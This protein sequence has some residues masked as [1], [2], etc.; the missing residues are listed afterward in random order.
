[1]KLLLV[2]LLSATILAPSGI[3]AA[4]SRYDRQPVT[5]LGVVRSIVVRPIGR[6]GAI[7]QFALC[8]SLCVNVV[9]FNKPSFLAGQSLTVQGT[10]HRIFSNGII[11]ARNVVIVG[12]PM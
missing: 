6:G 8:D 10:F 9:E 1:M 4:P 12:T 7:A 11:Q 2:T 3:M 5:V